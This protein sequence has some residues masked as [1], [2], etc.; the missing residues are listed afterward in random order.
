MSN[1]NN[2]TNPVH[3]NHGAVRPEN[4]QALPTL[5]PRR[6]LRF[7]RCRQQDIPLGVQPAVRPAILER[8][9]QRT[10]VAARGALAQVP[11][12]A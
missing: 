3:V 11:G 2:Q 8:S 4:G 6:I 9:R 1:G 7:G 10:R 5:Q 12:M